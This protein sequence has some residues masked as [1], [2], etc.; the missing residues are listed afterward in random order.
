MNT[1]LFESLILVLVL[2]NVS[3]FI[4]NFSSFSLSVC[5]AIVIFVLLIKSNILSIFSLT[6]FPNSGDKAANLVILSF[7]FNRF[8]R[9]PSC[10]RVRCNSLALNCCSTLSLSNS[11]TSGTIL[12]RSFLPVIMSWPCWLSFFNSSSFIKCNNISVTV[13]STNFLVSEIFSIFLTLFNIIFV[14][15]VS[16]N[17]FNFILSSLSLGG[18]IP[19]LFIICK[20]CSITNSF[21]NFI[22]SIDFWDFW[23]VCVKLCKTVS[24]ASVVIISVNEFISIDVCFCKFNIS[25]VII[26]C[27]NNCVF[28]YESVSESVFES[29]FILSRIVNNAI[30][31]IN[32]FISTDVC[33][34]IKSL[35]NFNDSLTTNFWIN[36]SGFSLRI[37]KC[38][39]LSDS[40]I[41]CITISLFNSSIFFVISWDVPGAAGDGTIGATGTIGAIGATGTIDDGTIDDGCDDG[42]ID[43]GCDDGGGGDV[44]GFVF[45]CNH[46]QISYC[47]WSILSLNLIPIGPPS[48]P[49]NLLSFT[50]CL[51]SLSISGTSL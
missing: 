4:Y 43:D 36:I 3:T 48:P 41:D 24:I 1:S 15:N 22:L 28:A 44:S 26:F 33:L 23:L 16:T 6:I 29:V 38:F 11:V 47:I 9:C 35:N 37:F 21:V 25:V 46:F 39:T 45:L 20:I 50:I 7:W 49:I 27:N 8:I 40:K 30:G 14:I 12:V 31:S 17:F 13:I 42:T 34:D 32:D 10:S 51:N 5:S 18:S 19:S 2:V